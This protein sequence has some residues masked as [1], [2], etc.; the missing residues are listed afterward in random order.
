M[1][2]LIADFVTE[3]KPRFSHLSNLVKPFEYLG[4]RQTDIFLDVKSD[5]IEKLCS[6]MAKG[7]TL[8]QAEEFAY[9]TAFNKKIIKLNAMLVHSSAVVYEG[10]AYLFSAGTGV[11]KSTHTKLWQK[12]FGDKV[13]IINDDKPV[14]RIYK[15]KCIAYG[16]PFD[17]GSGIANNASAP[18]QAIVFLERGECNS[19]RKAET[20]EILKNLYFSTVHFVT[21]EIADS[22]LKNFEMLINHA[23]F[24]ILTCNT[25]I[26][27]A[28]IAK[29]AIVP[30]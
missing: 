13:S 20:S 12:A 25:D 15:D 11:G 29:D 26:S 16:T 24:Y 28:Y 3:F 7:T 6:K 27:A 30:S 9:A 14:V 19:I 18:L 1:K 4:S 23:D 10:R 22:M 21:G 17:G 8:A 5:Y 2:Y